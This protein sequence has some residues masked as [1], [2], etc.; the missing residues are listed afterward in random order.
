MENKR[1]IG[2]GM[3]AE[4]RA[5]SSLLSKHPWPFFFWYSV[6]LLFSAGHFSSDWRSVIVCGPMFLG[7]LTS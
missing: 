4:F 2:S 7:A 1:K 3:G 6:V 5:S